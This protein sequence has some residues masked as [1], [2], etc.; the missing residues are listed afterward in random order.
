MTPEDVIQAT[1]ENPNYANLKKL[2][3]ELPGR[4][5]PPLP[6]RK[7]VLVES[8]NALRF[9]QGFAIN[10]INSDPTLSD[11]EKGFL[12]TTYVQLAPFSF[13]DVPTHKE[14]AFDMSDADAVTWIE[15]MHEI[16][17]ENVRIFFP[18]EKSTEE[19]RK[20]S[21]KK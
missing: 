7:M 18:E 13:G 10:E 5:D 3:I 11:D 4:A 19:K 2:V 14:Y 16:N 12:L 20:E 21:K 17:P 15:A 9:R 8:C 1:L 6:A